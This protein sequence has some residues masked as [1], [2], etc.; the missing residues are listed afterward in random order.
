[1]APANQHH[2]LLG[3][4]KEKTQDIAYKRVVKIKRIENKCS[5][6]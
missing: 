6:G 4:C 5:E 2:Y 3:K 1:M